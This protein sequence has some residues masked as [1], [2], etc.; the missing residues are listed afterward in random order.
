MIVDWDQNGLGADGSMNTRGR[1]IDRAVDTFGSSLIPART[2]PACYT[3]RLFKVADSSGSGGAGRRGFTLIDV[4]VSM[5]VIAVLIGLLVPSLSSVNEAARRVV[6]QSNVRQIGLGLIMYTNDYKGYLPPSRFINNSGARSSGSPEKMI[7]LRV[8]PA[9]VT[10]AYGAWDGL[11]VLFA[12]SYVPAPKVFYCPSHRGQNPYS[13]Y[14]M[15]WSVTGGDEIVCNYHYRGEGP[16]SMPRLGSR[17]PLT[18]SQLWRIDPSQSSLIA[19]SMRVKSD[20]NHRV[21]VNFFRADL[22]VHWFDD[23]AMSLL[24]SLPSTKEE[25]DGAAV[26]DTWNALDRSANL[27]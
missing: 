23:P 22:T 13:A 1:V 26:I 10:S 2:S 12:T 25:A 7:T 6:C 9:E 8:D 20:C 14:A 16:I 19:D 5:T 4:L 3:S 15:A 27:E 18:T 21:G 24:A 11:G 17:V